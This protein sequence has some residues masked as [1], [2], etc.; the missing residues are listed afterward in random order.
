MNTGPTPDEIR[1]LDFVAR[2]P[3][4]DLIR[5][6]Y[7]DDRAVEVLISVAAADKHVFHYD[8]PAT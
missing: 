5:T 6:A 8:F 4:L 1:S 2:L 3:V 7:S